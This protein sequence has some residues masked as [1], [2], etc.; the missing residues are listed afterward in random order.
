M[1]ESAARRRAFERYLRLG[2]ERSIEKLQT[3]LAADGDAPSLRTLYEWSRKLDWQARVDEIEQ[4]ATESSS[5]VLDL[6]P[7]FVPLP[8]LEPE[9]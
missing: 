6:P 7:V 5:A 8:K 3:A 1:R 4:A 2:D 9:R